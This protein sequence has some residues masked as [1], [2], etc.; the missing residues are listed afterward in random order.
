MLTGWVVHSLKSDCHGSDKDERLRQDER[1][2]TTL[3]WPAHRPLQSFEI[4]SI[5]A[6]QPNYVW[7]TWSRG[8]PQTPAGDLKMVTEWSKLG[9][10][11][12]NPYQPGALA[13]DDLNQKYIS[14]ERS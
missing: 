2:W 10:I 11:V 8:V 14:V 1:T 7:T 12:R 9:F 5:T 13:A 4:A 3:W 6:G